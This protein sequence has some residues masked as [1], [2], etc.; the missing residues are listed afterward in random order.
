MRTLTPPSQS[1]AKFRPAAFKKMHYS[2]TRA[3]SS[4]TAAA[5][6]LSLTAFSVC[7]RAPSFKPPHMCCHVNYLQLRIKDD[8]LSRLTTH[9]EAAS[10]RTPTSPTGPI[11][12]QSPARFTHSITFTCHLSS[13]PS[14]VIFQQSP[15]THLLPHLPPLLPPCESDTALLLPFRAN[16]SS[17][18]TP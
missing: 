9:M 5:L 8:E 6:A 4:P 18:N 12:P 7:R 3:A 1:P 16:K 14:P 17:S 13:I 11:S 2:S 10:V 15:L